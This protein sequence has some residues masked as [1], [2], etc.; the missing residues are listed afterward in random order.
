M[1]LGIGMQLQKVAVNAAGY[2]PLSALGSDLLGYF[3]AR[4]PDSMTTGSSLVA[5]WR[6]LK[7]GYAVTQG[8]DGAKPVYSAT[9]FGGDPGL[10]FDGID[11][12]LLNT[13]HPYPTASFEVWQVLS[14]GTLPA[15]TT[16]K[17]SFGMGA[18]SGTG[19]TISR[20]VAG[21]NNRIR[22]TVGN[23]T[24]AFN[25][26][27][28]SVDFSSRHI[29]RM[30]VSSTGV[31]ME[32]DGVTVTEA[33][34]IPSLNNARFRFGAF[35]NTLPGN[36]YQGQIAACLITNLLSGVRLADLQNWLLARRRL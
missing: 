32:I 24:S 2:D 9:S 1:H 6:C 13:N 3:E 35:I 4:R 18:G 27:N 36:F 29:A 11:D 5:E 21:G 10:T 8:T 12:V 34:V 15:D 28:S 16:Q 20:V 17:Y 23:G 31:K 30:I 22:G 26:T 25:S 33:A 14:Q 7:T 19:A